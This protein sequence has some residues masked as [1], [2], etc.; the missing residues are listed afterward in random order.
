MEQSRSPSYPSYRYLVL[1][2][3]GLANVLNSLM[4]I[5]LGILL[6]SIS[7]DLGLSPSEQGWLGFSFIPIIW[8]VPFELAGITPR[9]VAVAT[10]LIETAM[11][12]GDVAGPLIVGFLQESTGDLELSLVVTS[13]CGLTLA[14]AALMLF[15]KPHEQVAVT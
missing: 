11:R 1:V 10:G 8:T 15:G 9:G 4:M 3:L 14:A 2:F 13:L 12:G 7:E 5:S 6:P